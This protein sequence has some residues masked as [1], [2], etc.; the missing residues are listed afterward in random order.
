MSL[1]INV[2]G[3]AKPIIKCKCGAEMKPIITPVPVI[4]ALVCNKCGHS[5]F[6]NIE[7]IEFLMKAAVERLGP[8]PHAVTFVHGLPSAVVIQQ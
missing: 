1:I 5:V 7:V 2:D 6:E 3:T 8:P 4:T